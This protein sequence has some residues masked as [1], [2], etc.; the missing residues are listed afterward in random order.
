MLVV[1]L[2]KG[3]DLAFEVGHRIERAAT[4][5][6][7]SDQAEPSFDLIEPG[8]IRWGEVQMKTRA[9]SEPS[10]DLHMLV[11]AVVIADQMDIEV[12]GNI[13]LDVTQEG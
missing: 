13:S 1:L 4:N 5:G 7:L 12:I 11:R 2:D 9:T 8:A 10:P 3:A 6:L